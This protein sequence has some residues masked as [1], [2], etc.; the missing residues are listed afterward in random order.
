MSHLTS[1][2]VSQTGG[3]TLSGLSLLQQALAAMQQQAGGTIAAS[4]S[5]NKVLQVLTV[6][7]SGGQI[8]T[9]GSSAPD[10]SKRAAI[11]ALSEYVV[12]IKF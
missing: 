7:S 2:D 12:A 5:G 6:G 1:L 9:I 3:V 10:D 8:N 11:D 4:S